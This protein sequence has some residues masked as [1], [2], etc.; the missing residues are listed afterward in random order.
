[1]NFLAHS[2]LSFGDPDLVVGNYLGDFVKNRQIPKLPEAVQSGVLLH[3]AI[4]SFTDR[5]HLVKKATKLL[6]A[7]FSKYAPVVLD[8]Y[9]DYILSKHWPQFHHQD[10]RHFCFVTYDQL[11]GKRI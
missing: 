10:L 1:M 7:D 9:F 8:I 4:D 6:H 11:R 3:R 2:F 5:H